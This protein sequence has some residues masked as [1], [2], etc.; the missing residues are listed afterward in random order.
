MRKLL[1]IVRMKCPKC[2]EGN[3]YKDINPFHVKQ[4]HAMPERCDKC[5][6]PFNPEPGFYMGAMYVSY[7]LCVGL[8]IACFFGFYIML[9]VDPVVLLVIYGLTLLA[10]FPFI[11]RYSR[12]VYLHLFYDYDPHAIETYQKKENTG[13][14]Q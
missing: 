14:N 6:Q 12:V 3:M 4:L 10:L 1:A 7:G 11:F 5:G 13:M 9:G 8:F 2:Y